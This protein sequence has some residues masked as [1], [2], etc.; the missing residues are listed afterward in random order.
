MGLYV[1]IQLWRHK[2]DEATTVFLPLWFRSNWISN[3]LAF[4]TDLKYLDDD[5]TLENVIGTDFQQFQEVN[6][7]Y[8]LLEELAQNS[9]VKSKLGF[10]LLIKPKDFKI[11]I[12]LNHPSVLG[13][14]IIYQEKS[15][16]GVGWCIKPLNINSLAKDILTQVMDHMEST[17]PNNEIHAIKLPKKDYS[18]AFSG[19]MTFEEE[20]A[21]C[22]YTGFV[23]FNHLGINKGIKISSIEMKLY[24]DS[25]VYKI[26]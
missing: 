10:P 2:E 6:I 1:F 18:I 16:K 8:S 4:P 15:F 20:Q 14:K 3:K 26:V 7:K 12:E 13:V 9:T 21:D 5:T 25:L 11:W 19:T 17:S 23:D 24:E 22:S